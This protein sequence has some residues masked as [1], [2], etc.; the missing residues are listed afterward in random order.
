M[1]GLNDLPHPAIDNLQ[2]LS[3][4]AGTGADTTGGDVLA[5]T[6]GITHHTVT[7][8]ARTRVDTKN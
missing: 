4:L 1:V 8:D 5:A 2:S 3:Q 6:A 7:G